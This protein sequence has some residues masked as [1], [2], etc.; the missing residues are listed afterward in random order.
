MKSFTSKI[1][2]VIFIVS[3]LSSQLISSD[4]IDKREDYIFDFVFSTNNLSS[5]EIYYSP[6]DKSF[7]KNEKLQI[8]LSDLTFLKKYNGKYPFQVKLFKN[9]AFLERLGYLIGDYYLS[10]LLNNWNVES[11]IEI[12]NNIFSVTGCKKYECGTTNFII[13][14]DFRKDVMY[15]GIRINDRVQT[16]SEDNSTTR[17]LNE[18]INNY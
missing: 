11:P 17:K 6:T 14:V 13:I 7:S 16:Y 8:N 1:L 5:I 10:Y 2:F 18:W 15:V 9:S 12:S 3:I 4:F